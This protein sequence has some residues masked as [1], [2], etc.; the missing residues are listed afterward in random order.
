MST[1]IRLKPGKLINLEHVFAITYEDKDDDSRTNFVFNDKHD[2]VIATTQIDIYDEV[3]AQHVVPAHGQFVALHL[4]GNYQI[5]PVPIIAWL[6]SGPSLR[7]LGAD[8]QK[9]GT[10]QLPSGEV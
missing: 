7:A 9:Y 10:L 1:F 8:G 2:N 6:I 4:L 5:V 3:I